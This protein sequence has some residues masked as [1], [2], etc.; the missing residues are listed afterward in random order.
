MATARF[1]SRGTRNTLLLL[2][3]SAIGEPIAVGVAFTAN[4]ARIPALCYRPRGRNIHAANEAVELSSIVERAR[5]LTRFL[6][7]VV[8]ASGEQ[9]NDRER[10]ESDEPATP[11]AAARQWSGGLR[12]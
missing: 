5:T 7:G 10:L 6:P 2:V 11:G 8:R 3:H 9:M 4:R 1:R 12:G